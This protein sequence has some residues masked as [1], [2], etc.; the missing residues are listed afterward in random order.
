MTGDNLRA[1][2]DIQIHLPR[3]IVLVIRFT[4]D[5]LAFRS[6]LD[7]D[8]PAPP[9]ARGDQPFGR[10][11][12]VVTLLHP[13]SDIAYATARLSE[14]ETEILLLMRDGLQNKL[15]ARR[16]TLS[17]STVKTHVANIFR[18]I[19]AS[20]RLDAICKYADMNR[21]GERDAARGFRNSVF[22]PADVNPAPALLVKTAA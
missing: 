10:G 4:A 7:A 11:G 21:Q 17:V 9:A 1:I 19:G 14:R 15:I 22:L 20:N 6:L 8:E 13:P 3:A 12:D 5:L 18:K 2:H 16:L